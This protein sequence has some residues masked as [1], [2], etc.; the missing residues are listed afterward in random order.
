MVK[1]TPISHTHISLTK[2][3]ISLSKVKVDREDHVPR[4]REREVVGLFADSLNDCQ[5]IFNMPEY[6]TSK[7][8]TIN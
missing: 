2:Q 6:E 7:I 5:N 1:Y 8:L 4:E 3:V